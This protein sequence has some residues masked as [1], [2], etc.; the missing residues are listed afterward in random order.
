[1]CGNYEQLIALLQ[2]MDSVLLAFSGGVDSALLLRALS[3]SGVKA[4][5]IT[6]VSPLVPAKEHQYACE[7][8]RQWNVAHHCISVD[9]LENDEVR[10]N[11]VDRCYH[12]KSLRLARL[13]E[14]ARQQNYAVIIDGTNADDAHDYRPGLRASAEYGVQSPLRELGFDKRT[15]REISKMLELP[16]WNKPSFPCLATRIPF[17]TPLTHEELKRVE[18][19]EEVVAQYGFRELRVRS[20]GDTA[21]IEIR[22]DALPALIAPEVREPI[23]AALQALGYRFV[24]VDL[25]GLRS[26]SMNPEKPER[27]QGVILS[28]DAGCCKHKHAI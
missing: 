5:A 24:T 10:A 15:V 2:G 1:M 7:F 8:A 26:G 11:P 23:V 6:V 28:S 9:E 16:T 25:N 21:R 27:E 17:G 12:C 13:A 22:T 3:D 20:I 19:A 18:N 14:Y 4:A